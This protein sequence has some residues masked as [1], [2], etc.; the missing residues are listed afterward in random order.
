M[1]NDE[2]LVWWKETFESHSGRDAWRL[3]SETK[4]LKAGAY[5]SRDGRP[6]FVIFSGTD[7]KPRKPRYA[8]LRISSIDRGVDGILLVVELLNDDLREIFSVIC[9]RIL[10]KVE[11]WSNSDGAEFLRCELSKWTE[12]LRK[13]RTSMT[14]EVERGLFCELEILEV[15]IDNRSIVEAIDAWC[16]PNE[17]SQDFHFE[18]TSV[19]VKALFQQAG[20]VRISSLDQLDCN[21]P[22]SLAVVDIV[23]SEAGLRLQEKVNEL[24]DKLREHPAQMAEFVEKLAKVGYSECFKAVGSDNRYQVEKLSWYDASADGFPSIVRSRVSAG[25]LDATYTITIPA[26]LPFSEECP[27]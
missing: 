20:K 7:F 13:G 22:L 25:V 16:G 24:M 15:A 11:T 19:E 17:E 8:S 26:L 10:Y 21:G 5:L 6:G 9:A 18:D 1:R 14:E 27:L 3:V 2:L 12:L 4:T 23:K